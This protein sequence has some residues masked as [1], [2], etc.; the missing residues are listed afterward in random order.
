M[1]AFCGVT[2]ALCALTDTPS[3]GC[4]TTQL[5]GHVVRYDRRS[6]ENDVN[7]TRQSS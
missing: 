3:G 1:N 2:H 6:S 4:P 5:E 7:C